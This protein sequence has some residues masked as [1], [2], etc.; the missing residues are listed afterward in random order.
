VS[1]CSITSKWLSDEPIDVMIPSP[2]RAIRADGDAGPDLEFHAV[3]RHGRERR[4][5]AGAIGAVDHLRVD[6]RLHGIKNV[7]A[8]QVD[9]A[10]AVEVE[11]E[12]GAMGG[13]EGPDHTRHVA[14]G[15]VVGLEAAS[16]DVAADSRLRGHDLRLHDRA[17]IHLAQA[18]AQELEKRDGRLRP[19]GLKPELPVVEDQQE[20]REREQAEH[21][22]QAD[23]HGKRNLCGNGIHGGTSLGRMALKPS[24][25]IAPGKIGRETRLF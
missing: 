8:G 19:E 20:Q 25:G 9:G 16:R 7:A 2:T 17:G 15:E 22:A 12:V 21:E 5:A 6:A 10:G 3:F 14:A 13:D 24:S 18:H 23:E 1:G 4:F 11:V